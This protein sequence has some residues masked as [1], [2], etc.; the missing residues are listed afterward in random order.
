MPR[1]RP[2]GVATRFQ[3]RVSDLLRDFDELLLAVHDKRRQAS[4]ETMVAEQ[5]VLQTAVFWEAFTND[6]FISYFINDPISCLSKFKERFRQSITEKFA[7]ASRWVSIDLPPTVSELQAERLLDPKGWNLAAQSAQAL[8]DLA[9]KCL[10]AVDAKKFSLE[11]DDRDFVDYLV[12][13]RN[14]LSHRSR[15]SRLN[16]A[17][18]I[19]AL[20]PDG[21]NRELTGPVQTFAVYLR[22]QVAPSRRRVN[23][24]GE[25]VIQISKKLV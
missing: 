24:I 20:K 19:L 23:V 6:L 18:S 13:L 10:S 17:A 22:R 12:S 9:N 11:S 7:G 1:L 2:Q 15:G 4:L 8:S 16:L 21:P 14:Y 3:K 5:S 25:R